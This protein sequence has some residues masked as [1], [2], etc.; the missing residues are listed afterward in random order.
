LKLGGTTSTWAWCA[1][2]CVATAEGAAEAI[3]DTIRGEIADG[4]DGALEP[5]RRQPSSAPAPASARR[6]E[7]GARGGRQ[8]DP[9][10]R[11]A[12]QDLDP[13]TDR[14]A[15]FG[16]D[17]VPIDEDWPAGFAPGSA[18]VAV[19]ARWRSPEP[20]QR[21]DMKHLLLKAATTAT[22]QGTF[23]AVISTGSV[24]REGDIVEPSAFIT[25]L[26]KWVT[27]GK[28]VPL[29]Y[30]H[31]GEVIGHIDPATARVEGNEVIAKGFIDQAIRSRQGA[32]RLVKSG[33]LSRSRSA[34]SSR[35]AARPSA[36]A[37]SRA[38]TSPSSTCS[39]SRRAGRTGQQR[40]AR[41]LVQV[42]GEH[43]RRADDGLARARASPRSRPAD[44]AIWPRDG[45]AAGERGRQRREEAFA[46][47]SRRK[48]WMRPTRTQVVRW[49]R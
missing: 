23:E 41:A 32:W 20:P 9:R 11:A 25:A 22:D 18:P 16:G 36:P 45:A 4:V 17:T 19:N 37:R 5:P 42:A 2:T 48:Q 40:H 12:R 10:L 35:T 14:H 34:S 15:E 6:D 49:T 29:D 13:D 21:T 24:D 27:V 31:S 46:A 3:N 26:E 28:L 8:A 47:P 44:C 38:T 1:T 7:V 39:R 33:T 43:G 30:N